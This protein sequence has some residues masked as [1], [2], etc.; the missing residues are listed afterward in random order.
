MTFVLWCQSQCYGVWIISITA[1]QDPIFSLPH[2]QSIVVSSWN[3]YFQSLSSESSLALQSSNKF[4][5]NMKCLVI[6]SLEIKIFWAQL[7][8]CLPGGGNDNPLQY[9]CQENPKDS[10]T[11]PDTIHMV[12]KR[13]TGLNRLSMHAHS[14]VLTWYCLTKLLFCYWI[15]VFRRECQKHLNRWDWRILWNALL[16]LFILFFIF[17][18]FIFKL[19][20]LFIIIS[21]CFSIFTSHLMWVVRKR[22]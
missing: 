13:Q 22:N 8:R 17:C 16:F 6:I 3:P 2:L 4:E 7:E 9:P 10:G 18:T 1:D 19:A 15:S 5:F 20:I 11:W 14:E 21:H 12:S